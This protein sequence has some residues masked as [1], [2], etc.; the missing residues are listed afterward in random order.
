MPLA[1]DLIELAA[2]AKRKAKGAASLSKFAKEVHER[3]GEQVPP[4]VMDAIF[5]RASQ[6]FQEDYSSLDGIKAEMAKVVVTEARKGRSFGQKAGEAAFDAVALLPRT[7]MTTGDMSMTGRQAF[8]ANLSH[9]VDALRSIPDQ[10]KAMF[11]ENLSDRFRK[12]DRRVGMTGEQ[13]ARMVDESIKGRDNAPLYEA[14]GLEIAPLEPGRSFLESEEAFQSNIAHRIPVVKRV[15]RAS[16]RAAVTHLNM[17]RAD[18]FDEMV[19]RADPGDGS[20][21][22][23]QAKQIARYVNNA[24]GRGE[25]PKKM[26]AGTEML[27]SV[28]FSPRLVASRIGYLKGMVES[29]AST[30]KELTSGGMTP[31]E[32]AIGREYVRTMGAMA[33]VLTATAAAGATVN[34]D[35]RSS[36]FLQA[37]WGK[38]HVDFTAGLRQYITLLSRL[39]TN[40][41]INASGKKTELGGKGFGAPTRWSV[42]AQF[43][44]GKVTPATGM[45]L[46]KF[47]KKDSKQYPQSASRPWYD[48]QVGTDLIGRPTTA[49]STLERSAL[50]L[51]VTSTFQTLQEDEGA[52]KALAGA[53]LE[54]FGFGVNTYDP[55]GPKVPDTPVR[56]VVS[57]PSRFVK[58]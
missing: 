48:K 10:A 29:A 18:L 32:K 35:P 47:A 6:R 57:N 49:Y 3:Y 9:P 12:N 23:E 45:V 28:F 43:L 14:A 52:A 7:I 20:L 41:T 58:P 34:M 39:A 51:H 54:F 21:P 30:T 2:A 33:A 11:G 53:V 31:A 17:R 4:D 37:K 22:L 8:L 15:V 24:T 46:D 56:D 13:Y 19:K 27:S 40:S 36:E 55:R 1:C 16:E 26:R 44:R 38:V 42:I 50:P 25:L 5:K